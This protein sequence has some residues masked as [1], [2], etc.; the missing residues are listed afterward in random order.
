M[1]F[2]P[3]MIV[4]VVFFILIAIFI[5]YE[6]YKIK[7]ETK[8]NKRIA[9][10]TFLF[11]FL[12]VLLRTIN[13]SYP[14]GVFV[15]EAMGAYDSWCLANFGVDSNLMSYPVYLKS[16]GTGQSALYAYLALPFIKIFGLSAEVYRLPMSLIGCMSLLSLYWALKKSGKK[17]LLVF[18]LIAFLTI[19][20]W[21]IIKSRFAVDCN[22]CP[23]LVLIGVCLLIVAFAPLA[24]R[25]L[26]YSAAGFSL[27]AISAY[28]YGISWM[29][30]PFI[31]VAA[32]WYLYKNDY[33][34][35]KSILV[36]SVVSFILLLPLI[37]F[38]ITLFFKLE[39]FNL[40]SI[41]ITRLSDGRHNNT[42]L[43]GGE[44]VVSQ[45]LFYL[46]LGY[47]VVILGIDN[48]NVSS[49][50]WSG[51]FYNIISLPLLV[52]GIY[53]SRKEKGDWVNRIFFIWLIS[54]LPMLLIV[55][56]TV[57]HWNLLWF[58]CIYFT[59]YGIYR[60]SEIS[61]VNGVVIGC[62]YAISFLLFLRNYFDKNIYNPFNSYTF[63]QEIKFTRNHSFDKVYYP[64]DFIHSYTLFYNP[65]SPYRF[66]ETYVSNGAA[67]SIALSYDNISF[68]LPAIEPKD[69]TAYIVS[70][71]QLSKIDTRGFHIHSG[72]YYTVL[73]CD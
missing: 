37:L 1:G 19:N 48:L 58:P 36:I 5:G 28:G 6:V 73:W 23:D 12:G 45:I 18:W 69:K 62:I 30:L 51:V 64:K 10:F 67:L 39:Q 70:N 43:L 63:E 55:E 72:E 44:N 34:S 8:Q 2:Q 61:R 32:F 27:I 71:W 29:V 24:K 56:P 47:K 7:P 68:G 3:Y 33:L 38:A 21:H 9:Y 60:F 57:N 17:P 41:T 59:G 65:I 46:K 31:F 16:W 20:P 50:Q 26:T 11:L 15:D 52:F 40:G 53:K 13:L 22:I 54:C 42:T 4:Q 35:G 25:Q 66:A 14:Q 49:L